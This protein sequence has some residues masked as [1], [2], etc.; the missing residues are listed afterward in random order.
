M[1]A[2]DG[3]LDL[4]EDDHHVAVATETIFK[5]PTNIGARTEDAGKMD[6]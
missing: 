3:L 1:P 6:S 5:Y 4:D 2:I